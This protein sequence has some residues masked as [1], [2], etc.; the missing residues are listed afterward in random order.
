MQCEKQTLRKKRVAAGRP[1]GKLL[2]QP[3][4]ETIITWTKCGSGGGHAKWL[5]LEYT[6]E[7]GWTRFAGE[8]HRY[9]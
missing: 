9:H 6:V 7:V 1:G 8:L 5:D 3:R 4:G 2:Q